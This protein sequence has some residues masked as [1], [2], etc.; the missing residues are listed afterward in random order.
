MLYILL[1]Y[2][3]LFIHRPFEIWPA[4]GDYHIERVYIAVAGMIW[5]LAPGKRFAP[6]KIDLAIGLFCLAVLA[7]WLLSPWGDAGQPVVEDYLKIVV[8]YVLVTTAITRIEQLR[9][10]SL[11]FL[12]IMTVYMLHSLWEYKNGR[13]V[14]RMG[15][16]RL[17]GVD[18]TL[19]DPNSFGA[20]IVYALPFLRLFWLTSRDRLTKLFLINY[21]AL[22][23]LCILLT[24]SRSALLGLLAWSG[25]VIV[26]SRRRFRFL[27]LGCML[28]ICAFVA[29]PGEL[30][31]RFETIINPEVGPKNA[32]VSGEGRLL[33]L[34]QGWELFQKFPLTG[35]GPG[36]WRLATGSTIE[37]HSLYGQLMGELGGLGIVT[38]GCFVLT[39]VV[40]LRQLRS[41]TRNDLSPDGQFLFQLTTALGTAIFLLL[42]EGL[43]GHNLLRFTWLWYAGFLVIASRA[44]RPA[45][46]PAIEYQ[47]FAAWRL[48]RH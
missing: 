23:G 16:G 38:F 45:A 41:R 12:V 6:T 5:L 11:G 4:L 14:Y 30:Q 39:F 40:G 8:F 25:I 9:K 43:F 37:S 32:Q 47:P 26:A 24:G 22:S 21:G 33:G 34:I 10:L 35:C 1:G 28:A 20:S 13:H 44:T 46:M 48:A 36:V 7:A 42:L 17:I 27:A 31:N 19:G 15:I 18:K 2:M 29:L 3:F